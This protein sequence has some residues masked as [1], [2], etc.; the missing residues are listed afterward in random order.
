M[1]HRE[2]TAADWLAGSAVGAPP[3]LVDRAARWLAR[4]PA[5]GAASDQLAAAGRAALEAAIQAPAGRPA[6]A[7]LLA[8]DALVTLALEARAAEDPAGLGAFAA[9]VRRIGAVLP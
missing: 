2:M 5:T 7:D 4:V 1:A 8:A 3:D 9:E 6:A